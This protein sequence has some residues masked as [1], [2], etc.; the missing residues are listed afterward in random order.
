MSNKIE[1]NVVEMDF[2]NSKFE[3]N[4]K[5]SM[6]TIDKLKQA[7]KFEESK[8]ALTSFAKQLDNL[9]FSGLKESI[10]TVANRF[11]NL[12]IVG[13]TIISRITNEVINGVASISKSISSMI[14]EGGLS[15]AMNI[16][17]AKFQLEGLGITWDEIKNDIDYGVKD[18]AYGL[19][20]AANVASQLVTS[21]IQLGDDMKQ[22]LRAISGVASMTGSSYEEIGQIFTAVAGQGKVMTMQLRQLEMRGLNAA[23]KLAEAMGTT[24]EAVREMVTEGQIDFATFAK[25][26]DD[27]FGEHAKDS[28][29]TLTGTLNNIRSAWAR[30]GAD[31]YQPIIRN[32]GEL[33]G[34]LNAYRV[35]INEIKKALEPIA[36]FTTGI[37]NNILKSGTRIVENLDVTS[38]IEKANWAIQLIGNT[39]PTLWSRISY[40]GR[41]IKGVFDDI[42][43]KKSAD[44]FM[45]NMQLIS[46]KI[47]SFNF[48]SKTIEKTKDIFRGLFSL[49][50]A[51]INVFKNLLVVVKPIFKYIAIESVKMLDI[52]SAVGRFITKL[53]EG[54]VEFDDLAE[55]SEHFVYSVETGF[56]QITQGIRWILN[57][58]DN[59]KDR[60]YEIAH[61]IVSVIM[62]AISIIVDGIS[63]ILGFDTQYIDGILM[64]IDEKF[65]QLL[66][67]L[68]DIYKEAGGGA[69]GFKAVLSKVFTDI[70]NKISDFV[71]ETTGIDLSEFFEKVKGAFG[72]AYDKIAEFSEKVK[73]PLHTIGEAFEFIKDRVKELGDTLHGLGQKAAT[74][75]GKMLE[76]PVASFMA[77]RA[78]GP[79]VDSLKQF[80]R[81]GGIGSIPGLLT[82]ITDSMQNFMKTMNARVIATAAIALLAFSYALSV[83]AGS[84]EKLSS[85]PDVDK[86]LTAFGEMLVG[87]AAIFGG[88]FLLINSLKGGQI[89]NLVTN[90][91]NISDG[92]KQFKKSMSLSMGNVLATS[93]LVVAIAKAMEVMT[94]ALVNIASLDAKWYDHAEAIVGVISMLIILG[95]GLKKLSGLKAAQGV[96]GKFFIVYA[97]TL[98]ILAEAVKI[99][100]EAFVNIQGEMS[101]VGD[102]DG[103]MNALVSLA[104]VFGLLASLTFALNKIKIANI[105][106]LVKIGVGVI[107]LSYAVKIL[108]E[109][110]KT[111][112][113]VKAADAIQGLFIVF[114]LLWEVFAMAGTIAGKSIGLKT[115][116]SFLAMAAAIA[117]LVHQ[118]KALS[119]VPIDDI[120]KG[121]GTLVAMLGTFVIAASFFQNELKSLAAA[122]TA[123]LGFAASLWIVSKAIQN[124]SAINPDQLAVSL[125]SLLAML[126]T[127]SLALSKTSLTGGAGLAFLEISASLY[128][129]AQ[130]I[131]TL[132]Q[133][134]F[135]AVAQGGMMLIAFLTLLLGVVEGF[136]MA[137]EG[138]AALLMVSGALAALAIAVALLAPIGTV[139]I[140]VGAG[141]IGFI[142][143]LGLL[144]IAAAAVGPPLTAGAAAIAAAL[145]LI[146]AGLL[147]VV[148][149]IALFGASFGLISA[150]ANQAAEGLQKFVDT[151][152]QLAIQSSASF[153]DMYKLTS[154]ILMATAAMA[155]GGAA[156]IVMGIGL[157]AFGVG[158]AVAAIGAT[159]LAGGLVLIAGALD[160]LI[161]VLQAAQLGDFAKDLGLV[162]GQTI[163]QGAA[164]GIKGG[165]PLVM[166]AISGL[167]KGCIGKFNDETGIASPSKVFAESGKFI[168][169][170]LAEGITENSSIVQEASKQL[171]EVTSKTLTEELVKGTNEGSKQITDSV[172]IFSDI[173]EKGAVSAGNNVG[174]GFA[175]GLQ[176]IAPKVKAYAANLAKSAM[177]S[178]RSYLKIKS[179]SRVAME[180]GEYT[181]EGFAIGMEKTEMSVN[182]SA[183]DLGKTAEKSLTTA[184]SA[185]YDNL[186]SEVTDPTIKPVL[187]LSDIQNGASSIDSMLSR[188]YASN[189]AANYKSDRDYQAEQNA[190]NNQLLSGL[191]G[192][193]LSAI[194]SNN[195]SDLPINVNIQLV[196][197]AE[198]LF[199]TV[200]AE[201]QRFTKMNGTSLLLQG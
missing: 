126:L 44:K 105:Q 6:S 26:M 56:E 21:G 2:D 143:V 9:D 182:D 147:A 22:S 135:E 177:A 59:G 158:A 81:S 85:V 130:A 49:V 70:G 199:R 91:E 151:L 12:G 89:T 186:T 136:T 133:M 68:I 5:E 188:D 27:A 82:N 154:V 178:M 66:F 118:I 117:I 141:L 191:N 61:G 121:F 168:D 8:E 137:T 173:T 200:V 124:L 16:E 107:G 86:T 41:Q 98:A 127:M 96:T 157:A 3:K 90:G 132:G 163:T 161:S 60:I 80:V 101:K 148:A 33:V 102:F 32:E 15:R 45:K 169:L 76:S 25:A 63:S 120:V 103:L 54:I 31:F 65:N 95:E 36:E 1:K 23:G 176:A 113:D 37:I 53:T 139:A 150:T 43:P 24:E 156:L 7:L 47:H 159:A 170:G 192:Q 165:M 78:V 83:F 14:T 160:Y 18:T 115:S 106:N 146:G 131:K 52:A 183:Q 40:F 58:F 171:G 184:L 35:K 140:A 193:L 11:T 174:V 185:A 109:G 152:M 42:F 119:S 46:A 172:K 84:I 79:L 179:P 64:D 149:P 181:G 74:G 122:G 166:T 38:K 164:D 4:V 17:K 128:V 34:F 167:V 116:I 55:A 180:I 67:D 114:T 198:G 138:A 72:K 195:M 13:A 69:E 51:G 100:T 155:A 201:N 20:A 93:I 71:K 19:D 112:Q 97:V 162:F 92:F 142:T 73:T 50:R 187:D 153:Q 197:D 190:A 134:Q 189:I 111:L 30:V 29:K 99:M 125:G 94:D 28:N 48:N 57:D 88:M 39:L 75:L 175:K 123:M 108:A 10:D 145:G 129:I 62:G 196:G 104:A 110:I 144:A 87:M 194:A 77:L